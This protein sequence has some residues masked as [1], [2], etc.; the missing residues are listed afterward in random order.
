MRYFIGFLVTIL[1]ILLLIVMI[2][3]GGG[4]EKPQVPETTKTLDSYASTNAETILTIDGP[5]NAESQHQ[6]V[7][8]TVDRNNATFEHLTGYEDKV[9]RMERF[10]SNQSAYQNF[11]L[12]L[13][14]AGFTQGVNDESLKDERGHCP[15]GNRYV[16]ELRQDNKNIQRYWAT[17]CGGTATYE[18]NTDLTLDLFQAQIPNYSDLIDNVEL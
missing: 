18:G 6:A 2:F 12:A 8:I 1:L 9:A 3:R 14:Q 7:R 17:S 15:A 5:I 13:S 10:S 16:F 11:L 4:E